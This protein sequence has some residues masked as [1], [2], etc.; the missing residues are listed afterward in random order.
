[1]Q[2]PERGTRTTGN[3][4]RQAAKKGPRSG[5]D[6]VAKT[7]NVTDC[8]KWVGSVGAEQPTDPAASRE[9]ACL[10]TRIAL[11]TQSLCVT[12]S[13]N[14]VSLIT[15]KLEV[16]K[17]MSLRALVDCGASN[18]FVQRQ[19]IDDSKDKCFER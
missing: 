19:S 17:V 16:A 8:Q 15:L 1:M 2:S 4:N 6:A 14:E 18:N 10:L 13:G 7:H 11:S 9:F 3:S 12:A 5:S